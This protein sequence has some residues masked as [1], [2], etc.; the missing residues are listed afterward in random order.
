MGHQCR[1]AIRVHQEGQLKFI[2]PLPS[3][4]SLTLA[5]R[6]LLPPVRRVRN[7]ESRPA[8]LLSL[9]RPL[10]A[11]LTSPHLHRPIGDPTPRES[12]RP[13]DTS[14]SRSP[15]RS[16][17][18]SRSLLFLALSNLFSPSRSAAIATSPSVFSRT[19][20]GRSMSER[21]PSREG[22]SLRPSW[23]RAIRG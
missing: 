23:R 3:F 18:L 10:T 6:S 2:Q 15:L 9:V 11:V 1:R 14:A 17:R 5:S 12:T 16:S 20:P 7:C 4:R 19:F 8:S 21:R 22:T 13:G